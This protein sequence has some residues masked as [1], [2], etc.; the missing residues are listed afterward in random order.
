MAVSAGPD[1][2]ENGLIMNLDASNPRS[3]TNQ[4]LFRYSQEFS[5]S[6]WTKNPGLII[7]SLTEVA[8]DGTSTA[9]LLS[10]IITTP[11]DAYRVMYQDY[12]VPANY[13]YTNTTYTFSVYV[14]DISLVKNSIGL[15]IYNNNFASTTHNVYSNWNRISTSFGG[16]GV[17]GSWTSGGTTVTSVGNGWYRISLSA[18]TVSA[19]VATIRCELW[20][21]GYAGSL[22]G[23]NLGSVAL[24]GA[25]L[26]AST[27]VGTYQV[28]K[29]TPVETTWNDLSGNNNN[30]YP[31]SISGY[32]GVVTYNSAG[33]FDFSMNSPASNGGGQGAYN[34]NGFLM[35]AN[36]NVVPTTGSFTLNAMIRRNLSVKAAGDRETIFSNGQ[37]AD[38]WR[39]GIDTAASGQ[40]YYLISGSSGFGYQEGALGSI[41]NIPNGNWRMI[42]IV[43]DRA[44]QLGSYSIIGYVDGALSGT[45]T[46]TSGAPGNV[47]FSSSLLTPGIGYAGCCDVFAGQIGVVQAYNKALTATEVAQNFAALRSRF[48][49]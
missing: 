4:N 20:L 25:Q 29:A 21:G 17:S 8:P 14:K 10:S 38:G 48:G 34:G 27:S 30:A 11:G 33:F 13:G 28:T 46:I 31:T 45:V 35:A 3:V 2:V 7:T 1:V 18:N 12:T 39:F 44:A 49:I 22:S 47:P 16:V 19:T 42:T 26:E 36:N 24:W 9:N 40:L 41:T 23:E 5:N 43:F 15:V 32:G 6:V 37:G